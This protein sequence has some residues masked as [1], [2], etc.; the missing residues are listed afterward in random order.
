VPVHVPFVS[1]QP[2]WHLPLIGAPQAVS[3]PPQFLPD[4]LVQTP[5]VTFGSQTPEPQSELFEQKPPRSAGWQMFLPWSQTPEQQSVDV[6]HE[7]T[8]VPPRGEQHGP[9]SAS[10]AA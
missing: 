5:P 1:V 2:S 6:L 7:G 9:P 3:V 8:V 4:V 10:V